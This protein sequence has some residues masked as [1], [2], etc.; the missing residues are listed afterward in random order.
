LQVWLHRLLPGR[1][2]RIRLHPLDL[3]CRCRMHQQSRQ[4]TQFQPRLRTPGRGS[5]RW[6]RQLVPCR[7]SLFLLQSLPRL[8][9]HSLSRSRNQLLPRSL[10]KNSP[11]KN[12]PK[13]TP[14]GAAPRQQHLFRRQKEAYPRPSCMGLQDM[15]Y[16]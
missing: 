16:S 8:L 13:S 14:E 11:M 4:C 5:M 10:S 6:P 9:T 1:W 7:V 3:L 15:R 12:P 2:H